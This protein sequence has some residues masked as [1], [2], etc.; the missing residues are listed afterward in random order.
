M[1]ATQVVRIAA[2]IGG[3]A[4]ATLRIA[5]PI[6]P[7]PSPVCCQR[8]LFDFGHLLKEARRDFIQWNGNAKDD[9]R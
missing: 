7:P 6:P 1:V 8:T 4:A 9:S 2:F 5:L 3:D